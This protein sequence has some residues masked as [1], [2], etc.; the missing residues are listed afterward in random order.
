MIDIRPAASED[1]PAISRL[2][3]SVSHFFTVHP[4]GEGADAFL[5]SIR[6]AA[7][8]SYIQS[9]D[10]LYLLGWSGQ[11]LAG[12]I[13]IKDAT[14][15]YHLF[16]AP[17]FQRQGVARLLWQTASQIV[18]QSG[19]RQGFTVNSSLYAVPMYAH[20]GF[21]VSGPPVHTKGIAFVP[22]AL[23]FLTR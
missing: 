1:A 20:F 15:V 8:A 11:E 17:A 13:A 19:N 10:F 6:P 14:H 2:I 23:D 7:I 21:K 9:N 12:V 18:I 16:V 5:D 22:M 3:H 4:Q